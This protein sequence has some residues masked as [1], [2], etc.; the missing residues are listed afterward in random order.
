MALLKVYR[1]NSLLL[2][3]ESV[4]KK[5]FPLLP[6]TPVEIKEK[7]DT[8]TLFFDVFFQSSTNRIV[9]VGPDLLNLRQELFPMQLELNGRSLEYEVMQIKG[10]TFLTTEK[11]VERIDEPFEITFKFST[12]SNTLF[13]DPRLDYDFSNFSSG[14]RLS[15]TT[16]Q[17]DNPME[18]IDDWLNWHYRS[19]G[20][21]RLVLY[22]NGSACRKDL[23]EFLRNISLDMKII[24]VDWPFP[25]GTDPYMFSQRGALN[26]CRLQFPVKRGY[27]INLDI[28]E[29]LICSK[30]MNLL[31][32]LDK[33][34][35]Y[36]APGTVLIQQ[37]IIPNIQSSKKSTL[38]RCWEFEYRH[39]I[40]GYQG[41]GHVWNRYG[42]TKYIFNYESV[43]YNAI[44]VTDSMKNPEYRKTL[45][46]WTKFAYQAK[47]LLWETTKLIHRFKFPK[48]RI[49]AIYPD[50]S[51]MCF[52]H[53]WG[54]DNGIRTNN[55]NRPPIDLDTRIH[56]FE[57][58]ISQIN[59]TISGIDLAR[60]D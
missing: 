50:W 16:L 49:D 25:Y 53:F 4:V 11:L 46:F 43:G 38:P 17:M 13:I 56:I 6:A 55:V 9:G 36:P 47:K 59:S 42:R 54:L 45:S 32:F 58:R 12:F 21:N 39:F 18:W 51:E 35:K 24:F 31:T 15:L 14:C 48:P 22:D 26:H 30:Q 60:Q 10:T 2:P 19:Y 7:L 40:P 52:F 23:I 57:P 29:Y 5:V 27:C 8:S 3:E 33:R 41:E 20:V 28:D 34:L 37:V 44:H 1:P